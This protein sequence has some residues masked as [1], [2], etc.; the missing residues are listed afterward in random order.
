MDDDKYFTVISQPVGYY[1]P[2]QT[3]PEAQSYFYCIFEGLTWLHKNLYV[4]RDLRPPN[5][6]RVAEHR[7]DGVY[8]SFMIIDYEFCALMG[9]NVAPRP[10]FMHKDW[11]PKR[12]E[13]W[14]RS[15]DIWQ[16]RNLVFDVLGDEIKRGL[17]DFETLLNKCDGVGKEIN[18]AEEIFNQIK[19]RKWEG[20]FKVNGK[21]VT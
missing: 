16:V 4:H 19:L 20:T 6:L 1:R 5:I 18:A 3:I 9:D 14:D 21:I 13:E 17:N 10:I 15:C 7:N 2:P 12:K 8:H 11:M